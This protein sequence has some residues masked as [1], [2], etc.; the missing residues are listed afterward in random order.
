METRRLVI[1]K[2]E[3][4]INLMGARYF[5]GTLGRY[6]YRYRYHKLGEELRE[7]GEESHFGGLLITLVLDIE[8]FGLMRL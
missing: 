2:G 3:Q 6:R 8:I 7:K 5:F 4:G 1:G